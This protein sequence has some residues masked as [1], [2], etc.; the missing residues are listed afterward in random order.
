MA[1]AFTATAGTGKHC[2]GDMLTDREGVRDGV[3]LPLGERE[4]VGLG[5]T[6]EGVGVGDTGLGV[7]VG[8][9]DGDNR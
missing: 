6:G 7:A 4:G 5:D 9:G 3:R 8:V 2:P 1:S